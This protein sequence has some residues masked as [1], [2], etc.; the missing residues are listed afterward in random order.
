MLITLNEIRDIL[1]QTAN[2]LPFLIWLLLLSGV[3]AYF[4]GRIVK[5]KTGNTVKRI[6]P[7]VAG[8]LILFFYMLPYLVRWV[9]MGSFGWGFWYEGGWD[10]YIPF[11]LM[12]GIL[13]GYPLG[14]TYI[15][16]ARIRDMVISQI[17]WAVVL[18]VAAG[19]LIVA[20]GVLIGS[21]ISI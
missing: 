3:A 14:I 8:E 21:F 7:L 18:I 12:I 4:F 17:I 10:F 5:E 19:G 13:I 9:G 6:F 1:G 15:K 20:A 11:T 2:N 16:E